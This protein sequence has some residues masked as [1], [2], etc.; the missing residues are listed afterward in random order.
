MIEKISQEFFQNFEKTVQEKENQGI[1]AAIAIYQTYD[2]FMKKELNTDDIIACEKGC[3]MCCY[4]LVCCTEIEIQEIFK[5]I[6]ELPRAKRRTLMTRLHKFAKKWIIYYIQNESNIDSMKIY[7][8]WWGKPCP[9]LNEEEYCDIYP[10]RI[11]DCRTVTNK[12]R[13]APGKEG[14]RYRFQSDIIANNIILH[15]QCKI[16]TFGVTPI[17]H[18]IT[19]KIIEDKKY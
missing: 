2:E 11:I 18:W 13:C 6:D 3:G 1:S 15:R 10:V 12:T 5:Y 16:G 9:F 17:H 8:D 19:K 4:Q 7:V 14:E